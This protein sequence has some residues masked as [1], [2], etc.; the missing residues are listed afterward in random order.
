M[1]L[2][3]RAMAGHTAGMSDAP[4]VPAP[5]ASLPIWFRRRS[6]P[7]PTWRTW[8]V[9]LSAAGLLGWWLLPRLHSWLAV[10]DP[11]PGAPYLIVEGWVPDYVLDEVIDYT[12]ATPV[13]RIF[14]TGV[15]LDHGTF[16]TDFR[17]YATLAARSLAKMG[18]DPNL[19]CPAPAAEAKL[20]RTRAMAAALKQ[21][22]DAENIP[23][24]ERRINLYTLGT[25]ARRS[26]RIFQETLGSTWQV[27]VI[28]VPSRDY[29]QTRWYTQSGGAKNVLNELIALTVQSS[30]GE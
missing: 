15:P 6:I 1:S 12:D 25:H 27:G 23:A 21:I 11:V 4:P 10:V 30:G 16:L 29:D 17:D 14:T 3:R 26:R 13:K 9:V 18:V 22:L 8:F 20:E 7:L 28:A 5:P 19:I 24:A 2:A